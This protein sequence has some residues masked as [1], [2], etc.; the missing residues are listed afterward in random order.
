[1]HVWQELGSQLEQ[2]VRTETFPLG[3][4]V[5][6]NPDEVPAKAKRPKR[7]FGERLTICQGI[8]IARRY[9][10]TMAIGPEDLSC[11]IAAVAFGFEPSLPYYEEGNLACGMYTESLEAGARSEVEV[12]KFTPEESGIVVAGPLTRLEVEPDTVLVYGNSAQVMRLVA[13]ALYKTGGSLPSQFSARADCADI[14]IR[15]AQTEK[16]QVILPCYGDRL[17]GQTQDHEMAFTLPYRDLPALLEG[18]RGTHK[19]GVRYPIPHYLRYEARFPAT[20]E[21]LQLLFEEE[22]SRT[23]TS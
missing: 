21:K 18:L 7:D 14:V 19:G 1:M 15:T 10:W 11:P 16:P 5:I 6:R 17:F 3:I 12:P 13:G 4:K 22:K 2:F 8:S 20:Y 9:G 23:V